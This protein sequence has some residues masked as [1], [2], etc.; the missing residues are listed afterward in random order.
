M[1]ILFLCVGNSGRSQIAEGLAKDMLPSSFNI[2]SAGSQPAK[3][4]HRHAIEALN[5]VG[6]DISMNK[7]KSIDSLDKNFIQNLSFVITLCAEEV[8]P[9]VPHSTKTFH[10]PNED[11]D[12]DK[13]NESQSLNAFI[14]T[15]KK[16][17]NLLKKFMVDVL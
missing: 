16:I 1:N 17:F 2:Q 4:V 3:K 10:W 14:T 8:C 15:R 7:P 11:P 13:F 5:D 9:V 12:N 6:I